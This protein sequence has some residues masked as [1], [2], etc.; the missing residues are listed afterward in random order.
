VRRL[1]QQHEVI[2]CGDALFDGVLGQVYRVATS[3][4]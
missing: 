3:E 2:G 4:K 1:V